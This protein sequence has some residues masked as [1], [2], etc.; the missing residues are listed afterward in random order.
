[1]NVHVL[2]ETDERIQG[3][4]KNSRI[5]VFHAPMTFHEKSEARPGIPS[6]EFYDAKLWPF[7][8]QY[9]QAGDVWWNVA[10]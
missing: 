1:M 10:R 6:N 4:T 3:L 5:K 8:N 2:K 7:I 9:G